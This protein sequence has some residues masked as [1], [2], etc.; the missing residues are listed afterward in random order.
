MQS[1]MQEQKENLSSSA[2]EDGISLKDLIL[3][4][5]TWYRYLLS[6]WKVLLVAGILGGT[7]GFLYAYMMKPVYTATTT[8][9]L[10]EG[11]SGGGLGQ[12]AGIA[13][14]V[15]IDIGGGGGGIFQGDNILELYKSRSMI[16]RTLLS[17]V[18]LNGKRGLLIDEYID[19]NELRKL[20]NKMPALKNIQFSDA[21]PN[22]FD[23]RSSIRVKDSIITTIVKDINKNYL[24]VSKP[25]KKL[26]IIRVEVKAED[27]LFAKAFN[28]QI[29]KNVN[30][31]YVQTK[32]KK[33]MDNA[34]ILQH[35]TDSVRA[36]MNGA[37]YTAVAVADNTPNLNQTRQVQR[38]A[39]MQRSQF[40]A[41][42]NKTILGELVKNLEMS[43]M[44]LLQ[45]T[46]LIQ[47]IDSPTYPLEK[48]QLSRTKGLA[49]GSFFSV[50]LTA[51]IL[52]IRFVLK[53]LLR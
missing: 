31:F 12:Y 5:R 6:K 41:E 21:K 48:I 2:T 9:V 36:V 52:I 26:S 20:W 28:D 16:E 47:L 14:M 11:G 46:P 49:I 17:R 33:S 25:D 44:A 23:V 1:N 35:K 29:V 39:P 40:T 10:E 7:I 13:S 30:D 32:T 15:G 4:M 53:N 19:F 8:F 43:K 34:A 27:E 22:T 18:D 45:E 50:L 38:V 37:I 42:T 51:F 24:N 3:K